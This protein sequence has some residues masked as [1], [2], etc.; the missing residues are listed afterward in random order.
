MTSANAPSSAG[1]RLLFVDI[2]RAYA[3][4]MMVFGH[5]FNDLLNESIRQTV[6]FAEWQH[7]R[8][9]TA[10]TFLFVSGFAFCKNDF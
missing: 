9:L 2:V 1:Q 4:V 3:C 5:T 10:P 6:L 7:F 8:G